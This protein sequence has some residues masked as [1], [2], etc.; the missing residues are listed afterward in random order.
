MTIHQIED[1]IWIRELNPV[2]AGENRVRGVELALGERDRVDIQS[3]RRGSCDEFLQDGPGSA[4][5]F[6]HTV[7]VFQ[8]RLIEKII[9][10]VKRPACLLQ[11]AG[12]P[13]HERE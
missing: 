4:P 5:D 6:Q 3:V 13:I 7:C 8:I 9:A 12:M 10:Q 1:V 11:I 2:P